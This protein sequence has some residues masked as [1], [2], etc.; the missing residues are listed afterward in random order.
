MDGIV[1]AIKTI[2]RMGKRIMIQREKMHVKPQKSL[3]FKY[4]QIKLE[5]ILQDTRFEYMDRQ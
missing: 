2:S 3:I 4:Y 5:I 1:E